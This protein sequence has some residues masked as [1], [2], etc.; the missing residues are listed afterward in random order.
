[1]TIA[2]PF[3]LLIAP[4]VRGGSHVFDRDTPS[5]GAGCPEKFLRGEKPRSGRVNESDFERGPIA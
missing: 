3:L 5:T 1:M 4:V 2:R